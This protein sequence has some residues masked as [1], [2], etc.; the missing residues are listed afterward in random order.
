M[1]LNPPSEFVLG[2]CR[3]ALRLVHT[4]TLTMISRLVLIKLEIGCVSLAEIFHPFPSCTRG[5]YSPYVS[6]SKPFYLLTGHLEKKRLKL[7]LRIYPINM[8]STA[9]K[10]A[11]ALIAIA[12][13]ILCLSIYRLYFSPIAKFPGRKLAALTL[14]YQFYYDVVK[15]GTYA[16]EIRK[17]HE[18]Y[19]MISVVFL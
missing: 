9:S 15:R 11:Y 8:Y 7:Y 4:L 6:L 16:W 5:L 3:T 18:D 13:Y 12:A 14:W 19:G 2:L 10:L 1:G 17:M